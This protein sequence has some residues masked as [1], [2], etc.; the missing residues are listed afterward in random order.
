MLPHYSPLKVAE[1]FAMLDGLY[2]GRI[3]L[4]IGRAAGTS[5][6]VALALQRDRRQPAPDD[7]PQQLRELLGYLSERF[8]G[9]APWLLGSSEQ[10]AIWAAE[11]GL[12]Y[13]FADFINSDGEAI[14]ARYRADFRPSAWLQEPQT[15]VAAWVICADTDEEAFRLS[16]S[17]R[18]M[19]LQLIRGRPIRVPTVDEAERFLEAEGMPAELLPIGRR[20]ITGTPARARAGIEALA[21]D[22]GAQEVL[23]VN[24]L[25][26][27]AAR[28]RSYELIAREFGQVLRPEEPLVHPYM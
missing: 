13:A 27:H 11:L 26:S 1:N 23:L 18:M 8:R 24:I 22:Y 28:R 16:L 21:R 14:A 3:D 9:P 5:P 19:G 12:P 17:L 25:H 15:T 7:F 4:G 20:I 2:P 6:R 10:S